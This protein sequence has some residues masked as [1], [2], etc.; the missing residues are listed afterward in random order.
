VE[1]TTRYRYFILYKE[2]SN[3]KE[4]IYIF[5]KIVVAQ[6]GLLEEI[7]IDKDKLFTSKFWTILIV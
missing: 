3:T 7:I 4:L 5:N 1:R 6:H 2:S